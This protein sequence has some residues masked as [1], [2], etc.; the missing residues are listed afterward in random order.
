MSAMV[1]SME[2]TVGGQPDGLRRVQVALERA[3]TELLDLGKHVFPKLLPLIEV[4]T[5]KAFD[6]E[7]GASGSWA[8][9]S[10]SYAAWKEAHYPGQPTLV[11]TGALRSGLTDGASSNAVREVSSDS[12]T[13]GTRGIPYATAHQTGTGRMPARPYLDFGSD[14]EAGFRAAALQGVRESI[15]E[16]SEGLLDFDGDTFEGLPVLTGKSGGRYTLGSNG[17]RTYLKRS[18]A[19]HV[20]KR[21][22][23]GKA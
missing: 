2:W 16:A 6:D 3:G 7:G 4:E 17:S 21:T 1:L 8:P 14:F 19:G 18:P 23:G 13:F 5:E 15:R 22:F 9:L 11:R 12:L 10:V 20:V